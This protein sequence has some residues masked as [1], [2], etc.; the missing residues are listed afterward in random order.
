M[1]IGWLLLLLASAVAWA[2]PTPIRTVTSLPATCTGGTPGQST[3]TVV[4]VTAGVGQQY[5]CTAPNTWTATGAPI[6][7]YIVSTLP[8][9]PATGTLAVITDGNGASCTSGGSSSRNLCQW[10]GSA[11]VYVGNLGVS[12]FPVTSPQVA[13]SGGAITTTGTGQI[14]ASGSWSPFAYG[15][16]FPGVPTL[17]A[18]NTAG[19]LIT[20]QAIYVRLTF[21]GLPTVLPSV[22]TVIQLNSITGCTTTACTVTVTMPTNCTAGNLPSGVTGCTV[23][24]AISISAEKQQTASNACVNITTATCVIGTLGTGGTLAS[25]ISPTSGVAPPNFIAQTVPD[26]ITPTWF[27]QK[28]DGYHV[29]AGVDN[30]AL[31]LISCCMVVAPGSANTVTPPLNGGN[32]A[33]TFTFVDRVFFNDDI[34][35][36]PA[37]NTQVSINHQSGTVTS[38][39]AV[40]GANG[41]IDDRA[42]VVEMRNN[43][44]TSPFYE[45]FLT[46]YNEAD[47]SANGTSCA[48]VNGGT[49]VG[50][51][52]VSGGRFTA[53]DL[54][55]VGTQQLSFEGVT[56]VSSSQTA[57]PN[58]AGGIFYMAGVKGGAY[59][60]TTATNGGGGAWVGGLFGANAAPSNTNSIG[61]GIY[62]AAPAVRFATRNIGLVIED[63]TSGGNTADWNIISKANGT[64]TSGFNYFQGPMFFPSLVAVNGTILVT[65]SESLTG[66]LTTTQLA[67]PGA[68][69]LNTFGTP[70]S[71]SV[72]YKITGVDSNGN[73][74][75]AS[76]PVV[77][78]TANANITATNGIDVVSISNA[79]AGYSSYNVYRTIAAGNCNGVA[80]TN[81]LIGNVAIAQ[82]ILNRQ[83]PT[84]FID[85]GQVGNGNTAVA[86]P[87][88]T[89]GIKGTKYLTSTNCSSGVSP[90]V[91]GSAAAGAVAVPTGA[92]PTL[93]VNTTAVT[94]L[95]QIQL[96]VDE[97]LTISGTTCN[98]TL[99]TLVNP[100]VTA[101]S[102]GVSFTITMNS[103]LL[104]NPA[105]V[106]Y[107]IT[108]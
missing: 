5:T 29:F 19:T 82:T 86:Q 50:E 73:E 75:A 17:T 37:S 81:G 23:W 52:C 90:A 63:W 93:V 20:A 27:I 39:L 2:Q 26:F 43:S 78:N 87:N 106:S 100:V 94:A 71:T 101:R 32:V 66:S 10:T 38:T 84:T 68:P 35:P 104:T 12:A 30:A 91:C 105:C 92:T 11:W 45:Q 34:T 74:T 67:T 25:S 76:P 70:G 8:V 59:Q 18:Q 22:E 77:I 13:S 58:V 49:A 98:T 6:G 36:A 16:I 47:P 40:Q 103:T 3:D 69:N 83:N 99:S 42:L 14:S 55:P 41:G 60:G 21:V 53:N 31:N 102:P 97:S 24:D 7:T 33:G 15:T 44:T 57:A 89:G 96:N 107:V 72:T 48:P 95:S 54:R 62:S 46:Q 28:Q 61:E 64:S 51:S 1:R 79:L 9:A 88:T 108:N 85:S 65:G 4:L 56:G 80:C